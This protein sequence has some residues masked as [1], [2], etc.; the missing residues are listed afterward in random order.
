[1]TRLRSI[2]TVCVLLTALAAGGISLTV[3]GPLENVAIRSYSQIPW[4]KG[5]LLAYC[6]GTLL[7]P[8]GLADIREPV[9]RTVK[10]WMVLLFLS[11]AVWLVPLIL[12][13]RFG[14]T[15]DRCFSV[16]GMIILVPTLLG[17]LAQL[18]RK[19]RHEPSEP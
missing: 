10:V 2:T 4:L 7:V 3:S 12:A 8:F 15:S 1:M 5:L 9:A 13:P 6:F 18:W 19:L 14:W 16:S 17:P 11:S